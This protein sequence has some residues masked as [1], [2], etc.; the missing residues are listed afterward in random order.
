MNPPPGGDKKRFSVEEI[1]PAEKLDS[2][3]TSHTVRSMTPADFADMAMAFGVPPA[4]VENPKVNALTTHDLVTIDGLFADYRYQVIA[5]F[6]GVNK[7]TSV[8]TPQNVKALGDSCCCC[9][10]PC[11][12]CCSAAVQV[13]PL[14]V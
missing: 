13:D 6:Q 4:P 11:C 12:S 7:L 8:H 1:F 5:N 10:T 9:C 14:A 2:F 3:K